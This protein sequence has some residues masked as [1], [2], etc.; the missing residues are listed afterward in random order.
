[1]SDE[2]EEELEFEFEEAQPRAVVLDVP[3]GQVLIPDLDALAELLGY[4]PAAMWANDK[5]VFLLTPKRR[6][7]PL[8]ADSGPKVASIRK[9]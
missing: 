3:D 5:G 7:E 6:W 8:E 1:M 9:N 2:G 4:M